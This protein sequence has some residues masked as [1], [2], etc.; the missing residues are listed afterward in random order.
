MWSLDM[1]TR[2][3]EPVDLVAAAA[4]D[5]LMA[6]RWQCA[7]LL[8]RKSAAS[9]RDLLFGR[10]AEL[11]SSPIARDQILSKMLEAAAADLE[12]GRPPL[13]EGASVF[14]R[15]R[16]PCCTA[17]QIVR[18]QV[19]RHTGVPARASAAAAAELERRHRAENL[20][21]YQLCDRLAAEAQ[22][23]ELLWDDPRLPADAHTRLIMLC[24]T[25]KLVE[26]A[27]DLEPSHARSVRRRNAPRRRRERALA[28]APSRALVPAPRWGP[29]VRWPN[30]M[31]R[32]LW[33]L[34]LVLV[35][36]M[37]WVLI[38]A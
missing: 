31:A 3:S 14:C 33:A 37:G 17:R 21:D 34:S 36:A 18:Q 5:A 2:D 10:A 20:P 27:Q 28:L 6:A 19:F 16:S 15:E 4:V 25:P 32:W 12:A 7:D 30:A 26:R 9:T 24:T 35:G 11:A 23:H 22:L 1:K 38:D 8:T 13:Q 29:R